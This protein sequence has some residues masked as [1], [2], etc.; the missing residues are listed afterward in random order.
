MKVYLT[1]DLNVRTNAGLVPLT[2]LRA[3]DVVIA[4]DGNTIC[5]DRVVDIAAVI[6][7]VAEAD[8]IGTK[9]DNALVALRD[10]VAIGDKCYEMDVDHLGTVLD[11]NVLSWH[12]QAYNDIVFEVKTEKCN[13]LFVGENGKILVEV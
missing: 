7:V 1:R 5:A 4:W 12:K 6:T 11:T 2:K 8:L 10:K 3:G 13:N 9:N